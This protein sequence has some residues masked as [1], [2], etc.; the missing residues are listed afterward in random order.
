MN[1]RRNVMAS[2]KRKPTRQVSE[3]NQEDRNKAKVAREVVEKTGV[4]VN[5]LLG[6]LVNAAG[7][8]SSQH[9]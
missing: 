6:K 3:R 8:P 9:S 2:R 7:E 5:Q 4:N 1:P